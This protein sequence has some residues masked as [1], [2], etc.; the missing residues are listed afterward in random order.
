AICSLSKVLDILD[1]NS[2][3]VKAMILSC[4]E[5]LDDDDLD[6]RMECCA[7]L[8][9]IVGDNLTA[10]SRAVCQLVWERLETV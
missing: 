9:H 5:L 1:L 7:L 8:G 10:T 4:L 6:V 2:P 3:N